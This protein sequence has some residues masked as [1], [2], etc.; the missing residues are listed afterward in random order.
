MRT[1][2]SSSPRDFGH[3][4]DLLSL[5]EELYLTGW[6]QRKISSSARMTDRFRHARPIFPEI[7]EAL[8]EN[9]G[10]DQKWYVR[11]VVGNI[12]DP[13]HGCIRLGNGR[14]VG[15]GRYVMT[16]E[17]RCLPDIMWIVDLWTAR[18]INL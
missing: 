4:Y 14:F 3:N 2:S 12:N 17:T 7:L 5:K 1:I 16:G 13:G 15:I 8:I 11:S 10:G 6:G 9:A 18:V